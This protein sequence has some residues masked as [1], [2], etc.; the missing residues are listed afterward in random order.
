MSARRQW[1][2]IG[3]AFALACALIPLVPLFTHVSGQVVWQGGMVPRAGTASSSYH[4]Y[5]HVTVLVREADGERVVA[6][7]V[8]DDQGNFSINVGPGHYLLDPVPVAYPDGG[9]GPFGPMSPC[10]VLPFA[11]ARVRIVCIAR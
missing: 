6:Q 7:G 5:P 4:P 11:D 8:A 10:T 1:L 2:F 9:H 3:I